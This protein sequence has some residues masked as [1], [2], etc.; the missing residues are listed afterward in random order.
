M[1]NDTA[2]AIL[3]CINKITNCT[4]EVYVRQ[5]TPSVMVI[6]EENIPS[7]EIISQIEESLKDFGTVLP[8]HFRDRNFI[9]FHISI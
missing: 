9:S 4:P 5:S 6:W 2:I 1:N 8:N 7:E 3:E